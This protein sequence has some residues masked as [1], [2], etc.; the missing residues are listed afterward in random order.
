[1]KFWMVFAPYWCNTERQSGDN[2]GRDVG[3][4]VYVMKK[5]EMTQRSL[6]I[7]LDIF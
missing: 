5:V 3:I 1:M 7:V 6:K 4:G 2:T